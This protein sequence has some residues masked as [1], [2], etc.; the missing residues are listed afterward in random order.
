MND[1]TRLRLY[2]TQLESEGFLNLSRENAVWV[3]EM[4]AVGITAERP[5]E[6]APVRRP[7]NV[8]QLALVR[9]DRGAQP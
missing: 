5:P 8:V 2:R 3:F 7:G 1:A 6:T 9:P 4:A